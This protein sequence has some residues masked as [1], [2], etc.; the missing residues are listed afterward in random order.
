MLTFK[1]CPNWPNTLS[2]LYTDPYSYTLS[3]HCFTSSVT[4]VVPLCLTSLPSVGRHCGCSLASHPRRQESGRPGGHS[5]RA[6]G[7]QERRQKWS[8]ATALVN[9]DW[10]GKTLRSLS[11]DDRTMVLSGSTPRWDQGGPLESVPMRPTNPLHYLVLG[12]WGGHGAEAAQK[13]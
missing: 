3:S 10:C 7:Q 1:H 8:V 2:S 5:I 11:S 4:L 6:A 13:A 9:V 12:E